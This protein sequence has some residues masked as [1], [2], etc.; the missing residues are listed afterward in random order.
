M[1]VYKTGPTHNRKWNVVPKIDDRMATTRTKLN[2]YE[3]L[4]Y[5]TIK[6]QT[7]DEKMKL[8]EDIARLGHEQN[9]YKIINYQLPDSG[10]S[11]FWREAED[12]YLYG[13]DMDGYQ[14]MDK[15]KETPWVETFESGIG[16]TEAKIK[17]KQYLSQEYNI[18]GDVPAAA[19]Y[20]EYMLEG[21]RNYEE[22]TINLRNPSEH[23]LEGEEVA[24]HF[25]WKESDYEPTLLH[26]TTKERDVI[27]KKT[28]AIKG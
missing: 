13:N 11:K 7:G 20:E 17:L 5:K 2:Y 21:G 9:P 18:G 28:G 3:D 26:I 23:M 24:G 14:L 27:N 25:P 12:V 1:F 4:F 10:S 8:V 16:D 22:I 6:N 15:N 19:R